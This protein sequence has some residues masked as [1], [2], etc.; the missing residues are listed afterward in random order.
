M[1]ENKHGFIAREDLNRQAR[2]E[3]LT[4]SRTRGFVK[5]STT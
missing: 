3:S 1:R 2:E 5:P 4:V